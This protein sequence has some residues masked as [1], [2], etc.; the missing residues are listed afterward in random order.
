MKRFYLLAV[1]VVLAAIAAF[2]LWWKSSSEVSR[3][4]LSQA[5][6][7]DIAPM[8][9]LSTVEF[10]EDL[11]LKAHV[12]RRHFFG[13]MTVSGSIG[14]DLDK[15]AQEQRGDTIFVTLPPE[16]VT[17]RESTAPGSYVVIDTW[18]DRVFGSST[19]TAAEENDM[20]RQAIEAF[21]SSLY[22]RGAVAR[23]RRDAACSVQRL[24]GNLSGKT[25]IVSDP[26]PK[27]KK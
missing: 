14:F 15:I 21:R 24:L 4:S 9:Q 12:G 17:V 10:Y 3:V 27:G 25:V 11:P 7:F 5:K 13:R 18:N 23:A 16:I 26:T 1:I 6:I 8:V 20:K 19:F 22:R 2:G